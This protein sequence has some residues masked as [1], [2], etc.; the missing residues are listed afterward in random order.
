[1]GYIGIA[2]TAAPLTSADLEDGL[3]TAAKIATDAVETAKV[4]DVN[5]TAGKLAATQDLSTKTITLPASVAGLGTGIT[6]AQLAG[7]IDV[8]SKITGTIPTANLGSGSA[9]ASTYLAGNQTYQTISEYND[10]ALQ[11]DIATLALHQAT[12]ANAAKYNLANTNVDVYQDSTGVASFTD[13]NRNAAG[14]YVSSVEAADGIDSNTVYLLSLDNNLTDTSGN[15]ITTTNNNSTTFSTAL[16]KFGTHSAL[17]NGSNQWLSTGNLSTGLTNAFPTTGDF[18]VDFWAGYVS[19]SGTDRLF[20]IGNN[21]A[22]GAGS[23]PIVSSGIQDASNFNCQGGDGPNFTLNESFAINATWEAMRHYAIQRTGT[24]LYCWIDGA[25][26]VNATY[27][28]GWNGL[29]L[30]TNDDNVQIGI[31]SGSATEFFNGYIDEFRISNNS[32]YTGGSSFTPPTTAYTAEVVNATGNYVSTATVANASVSKV[33]IVITY[34]NQAG[35]NTLNTDIIAEVSANGGSNYTTV[36]LA[37]AGTFS[38]GVLQCVA[39]D[40]SVTAG[41]SIQYKIS[42]ANQASGSKEARITGA[43]LIY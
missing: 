16:K 6:N 39:N 28:T 22:G 10:D 25:V 13:C 15:S 19:Q 30:M 8:T 24:T 11:N 43:S 4:K 33:G 5:V 38:T 42:F 29:N 36:T 20:A 18:T 34:K 1:M 7:S 17:F 32:R 26:L 23:G 12:N 27:P 2:P 41:T 31:R 40:V 21:G 9:S 37:A 35:T 3:V 14:E